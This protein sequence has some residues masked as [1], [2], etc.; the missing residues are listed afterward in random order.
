MNID[1]IIYYYSYYILK[2]RYN[3]GLNQVDLT[4]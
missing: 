1:V 2:D 4:V 3:N